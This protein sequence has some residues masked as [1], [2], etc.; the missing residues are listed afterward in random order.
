[1]PGYDRISGVRKDEYPGYE[2]ISGVRENIQGTSEGMH[3]RGMKAGYEG[4]NI[5]GTVG[6]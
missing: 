6:N 5:R 1:M 4:I 3:I 2:R